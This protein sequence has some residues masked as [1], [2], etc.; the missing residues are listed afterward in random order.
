MRL[1]RNSVYA[2]FFISIIS[3]ILTLIIHG[4]PSIDPMW[5]NISIGLFGSGILSFITSLIGYLSERRKAFQKFS[6]YTKG[7]LRLLNKYN[8][9]WDMDT[10]LRFLLE[11]SDTNPFEWSESFSE[12]C[13][14][15]DFSK[16][17]RTYIYNQI[18][19]PIM[20]FRKLISKHKAHFKW[21]LDGSGKSD[22]MMQ[23]FIDEI[24]ASMIDEIDK[25]NKL[26]LSVNTELNERYYIYMYGR[27]RYNQEKKREEEYWNKT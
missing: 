7:F 16:K 23:K 4:S 15:F 5:E 10:K 19:K 25:H 1:Y 22:S 26:V 24:E 8:S 13:F 27:K 17:A 11:V 14:L 3:F 21:H 2:T 9:E 20:D 18:Y 6:G 12:F